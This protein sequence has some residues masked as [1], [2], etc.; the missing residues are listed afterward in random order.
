MFWN[1]QRDTRNNFHCMEGRGLVEGEVSKVVEKGFEPSSPGGPIT[2]HKQAQEKIPSRVAKRSRGRDPAPGWSTMRKDALK[3]EV[4]PHMWAS[5]PGHSCQARQRC[6][7][8][9]SRE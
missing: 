3:D 1:V 5:P 9:P 6:R 7:E 2:Q 4:R 8:R